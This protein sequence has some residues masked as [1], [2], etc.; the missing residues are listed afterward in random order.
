MTRVSPVRRRAGPPGFPA[1]ACSA[2]ASGDLL[3]DPLAVHKVV[4]SAA[5]D[6]V[7]FQE[8]RGRA[9]RAARTGYGALCR[10]R[11]TS[12]GREPPV[13]RGRT[14][15][16]GG[17]PLRGPGC[18]HGDGSPGPGGRVSRISTCPGWRGDPVASVHLPLDAVS[19]LDRPPGASHG[20]AAPPR[21]PGTSTSP[22]G[23]GLDVL[24]DRT[25]RV[26]PVRIPWP[27]AGPTYPVLPTV[28]IDAVLVT[29]GLRPCGWSPAPGAA[30]VL[31]AS[32]HLPVL[33]VLERET[34]RE[35][36]LGGR[37]RG[38]TTAPRS[39]GGSWHAGH[40]AMEPPTK[41]ARAEGA[42]STERRQARAARRRKSGPPITALQASRETTS[43]RG[44]A[45]GIGGDEPVLAVLGVPDVLAVPD[46]PAA[47]VRGL[48]R[49]VT[50]GLDEFAGRS[51]SSSSS[52]SSVRSSAARGRS[53][54]GQSRRTGDDRREG[55]V[56]VEVAPRPDLDVDSAFAAIVAGFSDSVPHGIGPWPAAEDLTDDEDED[57]ED[58]RPPANSV[59]AAGDLRERPRPHPSGE[60]IGDGK[61][62]G[63]AEDGEDGFVPPIPPPLPRGDV[64]SRLAWSAVIGGPLF[65]LL[66]ALAWRNLP[67][68]LLLLA[69]AAFVGGFITLVARMP[70]EPPDDPDDGA[71]V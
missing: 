30:D 14:S 22:P 42:G 50:G 53:R 43:P 48:S 7:C 20:G 2:G 61:D 44:A 54:A 55:A 27:E 9:A 16:S 49:E 70:Q 40:E 59:E 47:G 57:D 31:R 67:S 12:L 21:S 35:V 17:P 15:R 56:D 46:V 60:D 29:P 5:P 58:E 13:R 38:Q 36:R 39:S 28:R 51:S 34:D 62:I 32:D 10:S 11:W 4:R 33:A 66:A 68:S 23:T 63:D 26:G 45:G 52:S 8:A 19:R 6:V 25:F 37:R 64:V 71:V 3:G 1:C 18:R 65:L 41:A 24:G 69:L